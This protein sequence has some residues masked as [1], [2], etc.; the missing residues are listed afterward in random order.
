MRRLT[1][2]LLLILSLVASCGL[3][4]NSGSESKQ[5]PGS[6]WD[7]QGREGMSQAEAEAFTDFDLYWW[8]P[9]FVGFNL[10]AILSTPNQ[11]T[12]R[13]CSGQETRWYAC[14]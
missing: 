4:P 5:L 1:L 9:S 3:L 8:G 2:V 12:F 10:Q 6:E 11:V 7:G 14:P 13:R